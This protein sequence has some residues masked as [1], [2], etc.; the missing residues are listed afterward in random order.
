[1]MDVELAELVALLINELLSSC[2]SA[3]SEFFCKS[4]CLIKH[5]FSSCAAAP[6]FLFELK[7]EKKIEF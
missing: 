3:A 6:L 7:L 2:W 4:S 1:M 5:R